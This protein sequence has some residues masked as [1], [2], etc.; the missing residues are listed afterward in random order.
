MP[1]LQIKPDRLFDL[2]DDWVF[3]A[4][5]AKETPESRAACK[6]LLETFLKKKI[7]QVEMSL[8]EPP[9]NS[10]RDR[11]IR[12]DFACTFCDGEKANVE[13]TM[14]PAT[15]EPWRMEYYLDRLH[16]MQDIKGSDKDFSDLKRTYHIS[17][18]GNS[19]YKDAHPFHYFRFYD[20]EHGT[21]MGGLTS[22]HTIELE[23][24]AELADRPLDK[25]EP[26]EYWGLFLRFSHEREKQDYIA[27]LLD[28]E[29][30]IAMAA[31]VIN[32]F[33]ASELEQF[34]EMSHEKYVLD[35]RQ[36]EHDL[37][38]YK[39]QLDQTAAQLD[40]ERAARE[41][42]QARI[43]ELERQLAEKG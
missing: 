36:R 28:Q 15:T 2:R 43:A 12:Y 27:R 30:G 10:E 42:A 16:L 29:E 34:R 39:N 24:V 32:G 26:A 14:F 38:M 31:Q 33:T 35:M 19:V 22:I 17:F 40:Q 20:K 21:D 41:Q 8:N 3:K 25:L 18:L 7:D 6:D 37:K 11:Q 5:F 4:V 23:K 9:G 1:K 13:M